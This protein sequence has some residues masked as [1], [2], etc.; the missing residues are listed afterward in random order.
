[1]VEA[2]IEPPD[3]E[4]ASERYARRFA[5]RVGAWFLEVQAR[6]TLEL[7]RPWPSARVLEV[8][9]GHGQLTGALVEAGHDVTVYASPGAT[10][11]RLRPWTDS[12]RV[13]LHHGDLLRA[14]WPDRA[15][16]VVLSFRLV[17]HVPRW[18]ELLAE[19]SRPAPRAG[20]LG[21]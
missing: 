20:T 7:L 8:G 19:L 14:P 13:R 21:Y 6:T 16:D 10:A 11:E 4:T 17:A 15:F 1:M 2:T 9:G 3:V 5:G 18:R 12:G